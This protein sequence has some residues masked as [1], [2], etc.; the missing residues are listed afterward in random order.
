MSD[1]NAWYIFHTLTELDMAHFTFQWSK[2]CWTHIYF[3]FIIIV[4]TII[5]ISPLH[6]DIEQNCFYFCGVVCLVGLFCFYAEVYTAFFAFVL[7]LKFWLHSLWMH[8]IDSHRNQTWILDEFLREFTFIYESNMFLFLFLFSDRDEVL[9]T[10]QKILQTSKIEET[11]QSL[12]PK[13]QP[14]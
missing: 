8:C 14:W 7:N 13:K 3:C 4:I 6:C 1:Y 12:S 10:V 2:P 9:C 5:I 11:S